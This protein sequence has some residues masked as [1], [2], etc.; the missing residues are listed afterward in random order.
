MKQSK[1]LIQ[2][3][4]ETPRDAD[5]VSQQL[6]MRA[7]MIQKV[8]AGIYSYLPL[9]F[10][11]IRKFEEIVR[12][13]LAKDGCQELLMPAVL[14]AELWQESG[15]W[16]F[17][18]DELL[19]FCDRKAKAELAER[20]ARGEKP[21][22]REFYN[23]CLGPTH[24]EAIT[25]IVRKNVRSYKQL[26]MNLFQIQTK[27]RDERRPRFGLMRG[28]E[29][30]MK[31]G[32][33]FHPDDACADRMY[34]A[35]FNAYKRIFSRLGVKFRP[36]EADSG[37]IGGSFTHEFH[38]L[39]GSGEDAI[40]SCDACEY[41]SNIEKT[42]APALPAGDHGKAFELKRDHFSTPG[43]V[44][45]A[46]Q[47]AA[48][49]DADH[50]GM[51]IAQTS[52]FFLYRATFADGA[53]QLVGAVLRGDHEVNP[54]K[55]KNLL[56][57]AELELMPLEEAEAFTGAKTGFMGPVG[58]KDVKLLVDRSLEG[59]VNLTCGAN[60]TDFHH[61][62]LDPARDLPGCA[63]ADLRMA[64]EGDAC[65]RCGKGHYQAFRGIEVG[66]VF[67]LGLKYSKAMSCTFLDEQGKEN[68]M[69]MGCYGIGI[70]RTVAATIE[71]NYDADGIVWPWPL[72]PYHV[73]V[74]CLDPANEDV[75][76]VAAQVEK[77]LEAAGFEVL[78]DDREGLSPGAKFKDAD[79]LGFPLRLTVGAKGLKDGIVELRDRRTKEV[80]K[81][82]PEAAVAEVSVARDRL[83][84]ELETAGGR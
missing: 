29:F 36:V 59:A 25:D 7:G 47:A 9:A 43:I 69:V 26:P 78:H 32:Y 64:A 84:Q 44:G 46:E 50:D 58:L 2:T 53:T 22:E 67:K 79:L 30:S 81:L 48:M 56:G 5:V 63:F 74:V 49:K 10:R 39:A 83:L 38:V 52:K 21:D 82:K 66:Q 18:G 62:G 61:F 35:M 28:R 15:R 4:R 6:M 75:A 14:P 12:E 8:A 3:L 40:L 42:E 33:S 45:Q 23:F 57:A 11:S 41:T 70:T 51:P 71:Q 31:D 24:E 37:A 60:R 72:A 73:H 1:L 34:W 55:V 54:V 65:T 68:P 20:R 19:R 17:Y 27:F 13:E 16:K 77:D 76:G 80:V